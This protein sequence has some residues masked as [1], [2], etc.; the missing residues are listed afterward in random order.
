M[1]YQGGKATE[2][3]WI[4]GVVSR[5]FQSDEQLYWEPCCGACGVLCRQT[6]GVR[7]GSDLSPDLVLLWQALQNGWEPPEYLTLEEYRRLRHD[8]PSPLRAFAGYGCSFGGKWFGGYAHC[9][10]NKNYAAT[11]RRSLLRKRDGVRGVTFVCGSL[12]NVD[13]GSIDG[14]VVY[15]DPPYEGTHRYDR[16]GSF[17]SRAFWQWAE[18]LSRSNVVVVSSFDAPEGWQSVSNKPTHTTMTSGTGGRH[19]P[20]V[21]HLFMSDNTPPSLLPALSVHVRERD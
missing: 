17:D 1:R 10:K 19:E 21:E 15:I 6:R 7:V 16:V 2:G 12:F 5:L 9:S 18:V 11:A 13:P 20:V 8:K 4:A 14:A 3:P